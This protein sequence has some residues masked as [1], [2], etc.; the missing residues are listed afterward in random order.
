MKTVQNK[1]GVRC[2]TVRLVSGTTDQYEWGWLVYNR[3]DR[4]QDYFNRVGVGPLADGQRW[5]S[6]STAGARRRV[7]KSL[8]IGG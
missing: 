2:Q 6:T 8:A 4:S 3:R 5:L 7:F 1:A